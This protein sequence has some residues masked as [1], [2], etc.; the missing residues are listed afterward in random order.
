MAPFRLCVAGQV[1]LVNSPQQ[2][3]NKRIYLLNE[4]QQQQFLELAVFCQKSRS[5]V[6]FEQKPG[7]P[8]IEKASLGRFQGQHLNDVRPTQLCRQWRH[9]SEIREQLCKLHHAAQVTRLEAAPVAGAQLCRQRRHNLFPVLGALEV[10]D[11][12]VDL[13]P[14]TPEQKH[15]GA[16]DRKRPATTV[17]SPKFR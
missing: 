15:R 17:F 5:T 3:I 8:K 12:V 9:N 16:I 2:S 13:L 11:V 6:I 7:K 4:L 10:Q 1:L 14:D